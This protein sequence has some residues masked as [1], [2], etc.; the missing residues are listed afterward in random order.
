[1]CRLKACPDPESNHFRDL[2][3]KKNVPYYH[4]CTALLFGSIRDWKCGNME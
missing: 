1:M 4:F 3:G 2:E